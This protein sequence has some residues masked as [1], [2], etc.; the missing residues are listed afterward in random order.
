VGM[1]MTPHTFVATLKL[2]T[3]LRMKTILAMMVGVAGA[4]VKALWAASTGGHG[5]A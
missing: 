3:L 1:P 5:Y 2:M 4:I